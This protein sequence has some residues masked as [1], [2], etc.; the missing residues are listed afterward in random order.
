LLF[1]DVELDEQASIGMMVVNIMGQ[2]VYQQATS[3]QKSNYRAKLDLSQ[4]PT[5]MYIMRITRGEKVFNE[6][7]IIAR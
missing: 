7:I 5:G 4:L 3:L 1:V 2:V 6:K